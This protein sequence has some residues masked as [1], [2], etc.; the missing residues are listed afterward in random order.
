MYNN[1]YECDLLGGAGRI[2]HITKQ[3]ERMYGTAPKALPLTGAALLPATGDN[4]V[5]FVLAV[6]LLV[7]GVAVLVA[8]TLMA[9]KARVSEAK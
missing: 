8:S 4:R 3:G 7:G 9:R 5:L 2:Q 1:A 6:S